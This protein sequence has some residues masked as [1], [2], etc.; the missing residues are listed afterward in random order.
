MRPIRPL[1][2]T[3]VLL[4]SVL[5]P[6]VVAARQEA[7]PEIPRLKPGSPDAAPLTVYQWTAQAGA[8]DENDG[9]R[10]TWALPKDFKRG[11]SYDLVVICHG[12][13]LDYRWGHANMKPSAFRPGNI[14]VSVDG[15]S[16]ADDGTRVFLGERRDAIDFR[17][18][19]LEMSRSFP[20]DRI[21]LYGHSQGSFF[22]LYVAGQFPGLTEGVVAHASGAWTNTQLKGGIQS[23]PI[24]FMHGTADPVIPYAQSVGARDAFRDAG[25]E[26]LLVR[27]LNGYNH[28]P[29]AVRAS[30]CID[31]CAG[32]STTRAETALAAAEALLA[33]KPKDEYGFECPPPFGG[34][35]Q[36]LKRV[37]LETEHH[38]EDA[39]DEQ[40]AKAKSMLE[41]VDAL[42]AKHVE[43]LKKDVKSAGDLVLGLGEGEG[44]WLGHLLAVREDFRGIPAVEAYLTEIG[45]DEAAAAQNEAAGK[46]AEVWFSSRPDKNKFEVACNTLGECF[47]L[48]TL[49]GDMPARMTEMRAKA[50]EMQIS[51]EFI[52]NYGVVELWIAA[53]KNGYQ[54]YVELCKDWK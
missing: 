5:L 49:P 3:L 30:E 50:A 20:V 34:A 38:V 52:E 16:E 21:F 12:T 44:A 14:V 24:A 29:N 45:Y 43:A 51:E 4:C 35:Y 26:S 27:R 48:D 15:T 31:W 28:W 19:V 10:F 22:V 13:G 46:L 54:R 11:Q 17:D 33:P 32:M 36:V 40:R 6:G 7:A 25:H 23:V 41:R 8:E 2:L 37:T 53:R 47:L 1:R 42:A 39:D 18:F 9:L